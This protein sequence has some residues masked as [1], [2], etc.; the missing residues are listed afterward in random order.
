[1]ADVG[2]VKYKVEL[3]DK[4]VD[5]QASSTESKL[6]SKFGGAAKKVGTAALAASAAVAS[7]ASAAVVDLT[8]QAVSAYAEFEQL[9]GGAELMFGDAYDFIAEKAQDAYKN[10]QMS[11][12]EYLAQVNGLA[13]GL[14]TSLNGDAQAA[15]ELAD[16]VVTAEADI[17]A[18]TGNSQEA[19]QN[20]FN[21]I[22][23]SNYS[24]LDN[25]Q[26]GITP[27]KE[28]MQEVIDKV[29]EW[30]EANGRATKYQMGNLADMQ[31]ALVDY[32]E[33]QGMAN[34]AA[35]EGADTLAGS[36]AATK[37]AWENVLTAMGDGD[38]NALS[39][40]I[41]G[42]VDSVKNSADNL[43]PIIENALK[44]I[45][46]MVA[47]LMPQ[48]A[49]TLSGVAIYALTFILPAAADAIKALGDGLLQAL[50][51]LMPTVIDLIMSLGQMIIE[52]APDIVKCGIELIVQ[53][54]LGLAEALPDLIPTAIDAVIT[55]VEA[56]IDN[57]DMLVDAAIAIIM[58][59]SDGLIEA[60]PR[61]IEKAPEI[62]IKLVE[63]LI[64]N[65]PKIIQAGWEL[66]ISLIEGVV[67]C[68]TKVFEVGGQIVEKVK[69]GF[70]GKVKE[71]K[72]W[73]MDMIQNFI[74]GIMAKFESLKNSVKKC[75]QAVKDF[76]GFSEPKEGPLS[77]FHTYAPD[78]LDLYA[79]GI[80]DNIGTVEDSVENVAKTVAGTFSADIGYNMPDIAGYAAD[81]SAMITA[82]SSTEIIV[83]LNVDGREI[84]RASAWYMNEQLA[85]EAR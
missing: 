38:E 35:N 9:K 52:M 13:V 64:R 18:A 26:L 84:A 36:F 68:W 14:K 78:M 62:I 12:N 42:L 75:A 34:Y 80:D 33:M 70:S 11:Q 3:D 30:N 55:I 7:A 44:G 32:V 6:L 71:A 40:A 20:A 48:I 41:N 28:G 58:A 54:A 66:I 50:P 57:I 45:A 76:L 85:W 22:M 73:G 65:Y 49:E 39:K 82:S 23:K 37:A 56:L 67:K 19:V 15:A 51:S 2:V 83:P 63:A 79:K 47:Q 81:L 31:S 17:V 74:D 77:N 53:L 8:K 1:M 61:L 29:N 46:E 60:L 24:M 43:L 16:K 27:T 25:L 10:V 72:N 59:L 69:S 4:D 21:G 5:K